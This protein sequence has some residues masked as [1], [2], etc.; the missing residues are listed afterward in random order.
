MSASCNVGAAW[1][2][3]T[4]QGPGWEGAGLRL[5]GLVEGLVE[6]KARH[7]PSAAG[8]RRARSAT[9]QRHPDLWPIG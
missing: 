9:A 3:L 8:N 1:T 2:A 7:L 4:A 6:K 5:A